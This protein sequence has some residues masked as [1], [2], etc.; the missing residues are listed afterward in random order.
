MRTAACAHENHLTPSHQLF[1]HEVAGFRPQLHRS[2]LK[3]T[4]NPAD[5]EDLVQETMIRAYAG[6]SRYTPGTN[7]R[8]WLY[9]IMANEFVNG[10]R[11]RQR[12]PRHVLSPGP[13]VL[14]AAP[15]C[16]ALSGLVP[17]AP[18]AEDEV[19]A[20]FAHSECR[21]ALDGLPECFKATIYL[22]DVQGYSYR[23]VA[24]MIGVPLGT[25]MSRLSR[26]RSK[27]R[28]QLAAHVRPRP[29]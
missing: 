1:E 13:D 20:Q 3:M 22:A 14:Q 2:A 18:S 4:G 11:K 27:V 25:V 23:D 8:A 26:A 15:G 17:S 29:C 24:D 16:R 6:L 21:A 28:E 9:R 12:E 19:L 7:A 5:A 10:C